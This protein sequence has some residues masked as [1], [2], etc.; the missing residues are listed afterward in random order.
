M[1][2]EA[3]QAGQLVAYIALDLVNESPLVENVRRVG[4]RLEQAV[5][6][7]IKAPWGF[8]LWIC[9]QATALEPVT[10]ELQGLSMNLVNLKGKYLQIFVAV[11]TDTTAHLLL[12]ESDPVLLQAEGNVPEYR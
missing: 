12:V 8:V 9:V 3:G 5:D 2:I 11:G 7:G 6:E 1:P 10:V 4:G